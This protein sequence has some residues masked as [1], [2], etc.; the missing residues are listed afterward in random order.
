M[1]ARLR[2]VDIPT[3]RW[4]AYASASVATALTGA[5]SLEAEIHYSGRVNVAFPPDE[6]KSVALQVLPIYPKM[7]C[8]R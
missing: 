1:K 5:S 2:K 4:V 8:P 7:I 6:N 3:S